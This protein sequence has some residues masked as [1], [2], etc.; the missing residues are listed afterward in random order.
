M[1]FGTKPH[2]TQVWKDGVIEELARMKRSLS[3]R[4][5]APTTP[6]PYDEGPPGDGN[7]G[8]SLASI[9]GSSLR[10][11]DNGSHVWNASGA[12]ISTAAADG[13][14]VNKHKKTPKKPA[15]LAAG[16]PPRFSRVA[17]SVVVPRP[18]QHNGNTAGD[19]IA[20]CVNGSAERND[21]SHTVAVDVSNMNNTVTTRGGGTVA[22]PASAGRKTNTRVKPTVE[23][24]ST[25]RL[26]VVRADAER[27]GDGGGSPQRDGGPGRDG[28]T[29]RGARVSAK[30][31]A[32]ARDLLNMYLGEQVPP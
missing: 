12:A 30:A 11:R 6:L 5:S 1:L 17:V 9:N 28:G 24:G 29:G 13:K 8:S 20:N 7:D 16:D 3:R 27:G 22:T 18:E 4:K 15:L 19:I 31:D 10:S 21:K 32:A 23:W 14:N 26:D 2:K 25:I